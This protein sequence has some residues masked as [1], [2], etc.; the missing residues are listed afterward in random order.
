MLCAVYQKGTPPQ[1][2][3][4]YIKYCAECIE[5]TIFGAKLFMKHSKVVVQYDLAG[6][7]LCYALSRDGFGVDLV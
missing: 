4:N 3:V 2:V 1:L 6:L 7:V 5:H